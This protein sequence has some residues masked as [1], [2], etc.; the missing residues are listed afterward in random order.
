MRV[1]SPSFSD[2]ELVSSEIE[3]PWVRVRLRRTF[4]SRQLTSLV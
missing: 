4:P 2:V 1:P 3:R